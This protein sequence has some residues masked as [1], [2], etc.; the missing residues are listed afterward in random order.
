MKKIIICLIIIGLGITA[1]FWGKDR[2]FAIEEAQA[3]YRF[4]KVE[5]R[6]MINTVS[7]TG[8]LSAVV[9]VEVGSEVSGQIKE[10]VVDF[11]SSVSENQVIAKID[12]E[13]YETMRRQ[14]E[15]ELDMAMAKLGIQKAEIS[16][17]QAD[18]ENVEANLA[19]S[20]AQTRK[21]KATFENAQR[22]LKRQESL[23]ERDFVSKNDYDQAETGFEEASAQL[24]QAVA[25]EN[26]AKSKVT[27]S[28]ISLA[29]ARATVKESE[30]QVRLKQAALDKRMVDLENTIIRSPVD[31][32]IIDRSVDVGQTIAASLQAP[33]LFTIAQDLHKMQVSTSVDEAD[34]GNIKEGQTA[35]FT[36]DAFGSRKFIGKV[37]Q[38]RKLGKT[39]QNVVTY[40]V[41][42][43]ANNHDL[44]LMPGMTADVE[45]EIFK[46]PQVLTVLNSALRF[47]P[48]DAQPEKAAG[49][50]SAGFGMPGRQANAAGGPPGGGRPDPEARIKEYTEKLNLSESQQDE[51]RKIFQQIGKKMMAARQA[52]G[53]SPRTSMSA[54]RDKIFKETQAAITR[55]L[56]SGQR[57]LFQEIQA[58]GR[59]KQGKLWKLDDNGKL[60]VIQVVLGSSDT[61][62]TEIRGHGVKEGMQ[63]ISGT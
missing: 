35:R 7:A 30:A 36:V 21:A 26:A 23:V 40:E 52:S 28:R 48:P 41:I 1:W 59:P 27:S 16:R 56:D 19:A 25:Q 29:I 2:F 37:T 17:Y 15:A 20:Q 46:K 53:S 13:G 38:V 47:T 11:N 44:S 58:Q 61:S 57:E 50:S 33:T 4:T 8:T 10:L 55:I 63:V 31:G 43:S 22:N 51:L 5:K 45:I 32:V 39:V 12:P 14:A 49:Q 54:M 62:H 18:I 34:I 42:I 24:E 9:T 3:Q 60:E 6:D